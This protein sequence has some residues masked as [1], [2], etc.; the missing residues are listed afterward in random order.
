MSAKFARGMVKLAVLPVAYALSG[1]V[2]GSYRGIRG[3]NAPLNYGRLVTN[4]P[5]DGYTPSGWL[6]WLNGPDDDRPSVFGAMF[7]TWLGTV[8][9]SVPWLVLVGPIKAILGFRH[10]GRFLFEGVKTPFVDLPVETLR[11][12]RRM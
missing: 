10:V 5:R 6:D 11:G 2:I 4:Y 3:K 12:L 7:S 9:A 8:T 1:P